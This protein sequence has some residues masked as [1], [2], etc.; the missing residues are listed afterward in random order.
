VFVVVE[1]I[2]FP[3]VV[4]LGENLVTV[5]RMI[6]LA[7]TLASVIVQIMGFCI[8]LKWE[9]VRFE[10]YASFLCALYT[11]FSVVDS[12]GETIQLVQFNTQMSLQNS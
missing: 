7:T 9:Y 3:I 4:I 6:Q 8:F 10:A 1:M 2:V 5:V 11:S 12:L